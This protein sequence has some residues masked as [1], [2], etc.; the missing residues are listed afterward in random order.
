MMLLRLAIRTVL[1]TQ[2]I[3]TWRNFSIQKTNDCVQRSLNSCVRII[4]CNKNMQADIDLDFRP[5]DE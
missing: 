4:A 5:S 1:S 3:V 2:R